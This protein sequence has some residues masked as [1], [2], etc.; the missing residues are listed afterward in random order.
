MVMLM[1]LEVCCEAAEEALCDAQAMA[2]GPLPPDGVLRKGRD[3]RK[4]RTVRLVRGPKVRKVRADAGDPAD[5]PLTHLERDGSVAPILDQRGGSKKGFG[6]ETVLRPMVSLTTVLL[7]DPTVGRRRLS[8]G[9]LGRGSRLRL[10]SSKGKVSWGMV[11]YEWVA[12][13]LP[14][15]SDF[16]RRVLIDRR[17]HAIRTWKEW[18]HEN[19]SAHPYWLVKSDLIL[20]SLILVG[21]CAGVGVGVGAG[22][23]CGVWRV[24]C[25][26]EELREWGGEGMRG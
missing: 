13:L 16:L 6:L 19:H 7:I 17:D 26:C 22:V 23:A 12:L 3:A 10:T 21:V 9:Q 20:P 4:T 2:G 24:A 5:A 25:G 1:G 14:Q 18:I 15:H 11:F 8:M